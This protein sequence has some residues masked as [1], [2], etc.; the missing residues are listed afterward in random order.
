MPGKYSI[1]TRAS[2]DRGNAQPEIAQFNEGG[3]LC[4]A[5]VDHPVTVTQHG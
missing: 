2:D 5:V 4:G 1:R 3:Y